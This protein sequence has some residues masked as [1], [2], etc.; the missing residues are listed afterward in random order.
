MNLKTLASHTLDLDLLPESPTVLDVGCRN[1]D[2]A[3]AVLLER[4]KARVIALDPARDVYEA[5]KQNERRDGRIRYWPYALVEP[6]LEGPQTFAHFSTG[7]A[8][9]VTALGAPP[10]ADMETYIVS[11]VTIQGLM[12]TWEIRHWDAV[13][14]DCEGAEAGILEFWPGPIATQISVEFH[15]WDKPLQRSEGYYEHLWKLLPWYRAVQH[16]LS[17]QGEGVGHWDSL[18]VRV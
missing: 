12:Q 2:F 4:P 16:E 9:Y 10:A 13:K 6:G 18:L 8:D 14:L 3:N 11:C 17:K 1:W 5:W 15:D 7:E